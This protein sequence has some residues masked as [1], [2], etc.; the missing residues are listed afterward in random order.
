MN[1]NPFILKI[2]NE[3]DYKIYYFETKI[4]EKT[5]KL[6]EPKMNDVHIWTIMTEN[7]FANCKK[8]NT[9]FAFVFNLHNLKTVP[10]LIVLDVCKFFI[11]NKEIL[12][13]LLISNCIIMNND[14]VKGFIDLFLKFYIPIKP[15]KL[16][17]DIEDSKIFINHCFNNDVK[18]NEIIY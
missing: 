12:K 18:Y 6:Y 10:P 3:E 9:K 14:N 17:K 15:I 4:D 1:N 8:M 13:S 7:F 16:C 11:E 5:G 2:I